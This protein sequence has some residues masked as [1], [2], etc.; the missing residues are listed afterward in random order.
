MA[1]GL[2]SG[3]IVG[4]MAGAA[5]GLL[6]APKAGQETRKFAKERGSKYVEGIKAKVKRGAS[7]ET[8]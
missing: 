5:A 6:W 4:A 2:V 1:K 8:A 7:K 3:L